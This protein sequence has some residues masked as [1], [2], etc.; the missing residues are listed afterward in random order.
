MHTRTFIGREIICHYFPVNLILFLSHISSLKY[1]NIF[2]TY[3]TT[4]DNIHNV[5]L[6]GE[7]VMQKSVRECVSVSLCAR[8][9]ECVC[10][11]ACV[12]V[13]LS[14]CMCVCGNRDLKTKE[15]EGGGDGQR[16]G[17]GEEGG[18]EGQQGY[19]GRTKHTHTNPSLECL[20]E[21]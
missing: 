15:Q 5:C 17:G 1:L 20:R 10:L 19:C 9:I 12:F 2:L 13:Y 6:R 14:I 11:C 21:S 8:A 4:R 7:F 3:L 16:E 18:G